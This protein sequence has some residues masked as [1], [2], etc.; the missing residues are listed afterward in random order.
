[1]L[2]A[3]ATQPHYLDHLHAM[4]T[5]VPTRWLTTPNVARHALSLGLH[6]EIGIPR[7]PG[8]PVIVAGYRDARDVHPS[9]PLALVEH[10]A[11]QGYL[12]VE[13]QGYPGGP[14]WERLGLLIA[15]G[16]HAARR[17]S[18]SYDRLEVVEAGCPRLAG[19]PARPRGGET[20]AVTFHWPCRQ[21]PETWPALRDWWP[22][23]ERLV[24]SRRYDVVGHWHPRWET[25]SGN[26]L[27]RRWERLGV[28]TVA[29][30]RELFA[31]ADLLVADN[32]SLLYEFAALDR[33]VVVLNSERYR[34]NVEHGLRF[35]SHV[36]GHMLDPGDDLVTGIATA[37]R[38]D[39][40][41][42][43]MRR[44]ATIEAYGT[45]DHAG[46]AWVAAAAITRWLDTSE[47]RSG[48]TS[49]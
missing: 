12:G 8:G 23:I 21:A 40:V 18:R 22:Q 4:L 34:K 30:A 14:G 37:F 47:V 2:T 19:L 1:M 31:E 11:G 24:A 38:G 7:Q 29:T 5:H 49:S 10:G 43:E 32:T 33:P 45:V 42:Q 6:A 36:P 26:R 41:Q 20:V 27:R 28:R 35:W 48:S 46:G 15:G 39:P 13:H 17:W 16:R 44:R 9:R 25:P 3:Y